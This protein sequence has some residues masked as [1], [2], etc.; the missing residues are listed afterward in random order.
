MDTESRKNVQRADA[1]AAR[2]A[3]TE[4]QREEYS[5]AICAALAEHPAVR[6]AEIIMCY[7]AF[8]TEVR[9]DALIERL[10][11]EGKTVA[12]PRCCDN[13]DME[14]WAPN[15]PDALRPGMYGVQE[16]VPER[17]VYIP[18]ESIDV[19]VVPCVAFDADRGR[20]GHGDGWYDRF[21]PRCVNAVR[22][23]AA[24]EAQK[25]ERVERNEFDVAPDAAVTEKRAY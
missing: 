14:A 21:L 7:S 11:G 22:I 5:R 15:T 9:L 19:V 12:Y 18:P 25:T 1:L 4:A 6:S 13:G 16:P 2:R 23:I 17:S 8:D 20:L 3:L 24:F 10:E